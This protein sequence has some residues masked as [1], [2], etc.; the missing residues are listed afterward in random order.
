MS[1]GFRIAPLRDRTSGEAGWAPLGARW[2]C[3]ENREC[4][5]VGI[6]VPESNTVQAFDPGV[7]QDLRRELVTRVARTRQSDDARGAL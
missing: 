6:G 2:T 5:I 3:I 1:I 7:F 4:R